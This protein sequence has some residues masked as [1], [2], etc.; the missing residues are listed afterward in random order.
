MLPDI[1]QEALPAG[2][3][4]VVACDRV[5]AGDEA[6]SECAADESRTTGN[7]TMQR[8]YL[9][10]WWGSV[11]P[12]CDILSFSRLLA[13]L[14][15]VALAAILVALGIAP[16][17]KKVGADFPGYFVASKIVADGGEVERLYDIPWFQAQMRHYAIG[18]PSK[19]KFSPFPPPTA[20][21]LVPL[22]PLSAANALR[23]LTV[24]SV[25]CLAGSAVLL[26]KILSWRVLNAAIFVLLSG[27]AV[28]SGLRFGQPYIVI[29]ALCLLGYYAAV[30]AKPRTAGIC[31]GLFAPIKYFPVVFLLYF[32]ARRQW[33]VVLGGAIA[34][35]AVLTLSIGVLGLNLHEQFLSSVLGHHLIGELGMQDPF[36]ASF[37]SFDSLFRRLFVFDETLNPHPFAPLPGAQILGLALTKTVLVLAA[38]AALVKRARATG[39]LEAA[40][41]LGIAGILILLI[42][43]AT[44]TYHFV[45]LWLPLGLLARYFVDQRSPVHAGVLIGLYALMGYFPYALTQPF[46]GRGAL[47]L[48]AYPRLWLLTALFGCCLHF[49]WRAPASPAHTP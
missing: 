49:I 40:P 13:I 41:A 47:T 34:I 1:R 35:L 38:V 29:S 48:I 32:A 24:L 25:L 33:A 2:R 46:D 11:E 8:G 28:L 30:R 21:L 27:Y 7:K 36:T 31:F 39:R 10:N 19:G 26:A 5:A 42:A 14:L 3:E 18:D 15:F 12:G 16:P 37:Q 44:A 6:F 4:V 45:L 9:P 23:V 43:P 20:L 17:M 22:T